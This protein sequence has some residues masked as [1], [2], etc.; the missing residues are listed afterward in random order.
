M[1]PNIPI[2]SLFLYTYLTRGIET[3]GNSWERVLPK[4]KNLQK[5]SILIKNK[6]A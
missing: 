3:I 1:N 5:C 6:F 4:E 2:C